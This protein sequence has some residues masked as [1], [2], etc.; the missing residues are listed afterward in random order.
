M[1]VG[2][3]P[4]DRNRLKETDSSGKA[5][6]LLRGGRK[7]GDR[8]TARTRPVANGMINEQRSSDYVA[9]QETKSTQGDSE[10]TGETESS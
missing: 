10:E 3:L 8:Q 4:S 1:A 6:P 7:R 2:A 5:E 9:A